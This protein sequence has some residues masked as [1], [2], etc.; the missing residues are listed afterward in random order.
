[1]DDEVGN[2]DPQ[3]ATHAR[4][5]GVDVER[6]LSEEVHSESFRKDTEDSFQVALNSHQ[7]LT[8]QVLAKVVDLVLLVLLILVTMVQEVELM[9][10]VI[11][12]KEILGNA[13]K[14][15]IQ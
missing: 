12:E 10:E 15:N 2:P 1:M 6:V 7:E 4:E 9:M 11:T 14:I 5:F 13:N 8:P 3:I